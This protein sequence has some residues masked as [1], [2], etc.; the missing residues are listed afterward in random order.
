MGSVEKSL[1]ASFAASAFFLSLSALAASL[2][3]TLGSLASA[4]LSPKPARKATLLS[5][6]CS[7]FASSLQHLL[8]APHGQKMTGNET[9]SGVFLIG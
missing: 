7:S 2:F 8:R 3:L 6:S 5:A 4:N 1:L 9:S